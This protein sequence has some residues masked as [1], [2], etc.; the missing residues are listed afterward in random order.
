MTAPRLCGSPQGALWLTRWETQMSFA[1]YPP[2]RS[3]TMY[4]LSPLCVIA[5]WISD[6]GELTTGPKLISGDH[7]LTGS[8]AAHTDPVH[9][10]VM[11]TIA[12]S[13]VANFISA[14]SSYLS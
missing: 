6:D 7:P 5:T 4:R 11:L 12:A 2:G 3:L 10:A 8:V 13:Q 14:L 1:P 9:V